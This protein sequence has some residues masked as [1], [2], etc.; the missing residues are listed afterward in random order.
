MTGIV[1]VAMNYLKN[2]DFSSR[3]LLDIQNLGLYRGG[4]KWSKVDTNEGG[5]EH[6]P[7]QLLS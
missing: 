7:G 3:F 6:V 2:R 5:P 1:L 4:A